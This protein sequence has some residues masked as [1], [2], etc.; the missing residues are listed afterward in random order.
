MNTLVTRGM[1]RRLLACLLSVL[2]MAV[3]ACG[4]AGL[5]ALS[6]GSLDLDSG[7][8]APAAAETQDLPASFR[9]YLNAVGQA[10]ALD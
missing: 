4:C 7:E 5:L 3:G 8:I 10:L 6:R 9:D 1:R 2:S